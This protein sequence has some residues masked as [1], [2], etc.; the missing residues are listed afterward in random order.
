VFIFRYITPG[1]FDSYSWQLLENKQRFISSFL[2][3]TA[4][5]RDTEDIGEAVLNYSEIK[6]AC[7]GNPLVKKRVETANTI[8]RLKIASAQKQQQ[9]LDLTTVISQTPKKIEKLCQLR[10]IT[11]KDSKLY[12]RYKE[13][14]PNEE[15]IAFGEELLEALKENNLVNKERTFAEY[16]GFTIILPANMFIEKPY[17]YV[18]SR[19]HGVYYNDMTD[20]S[21]PLGCT[22]SIDYLL[23]H[24]DDRIRD[25]TKQIHKA[26]KDCEDA[27]SDY[28]L[29]NPYNAKIQKLTK[30][31]EKIDE[32]IAKQEEEKK[33]ATSKQ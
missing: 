4:K 28:N 9:L 29:G 8:E 3:G 11:R 20:V 33:D 14:I 30:E 15:R 2:S 26:K 18:R 22:K 25:Y 16:Q 24:F 21:T 12:K 32:E 23:E 5:V 31:L 1:S 7:I 17:V 27:K 6:A 13:T 10:E 19:N